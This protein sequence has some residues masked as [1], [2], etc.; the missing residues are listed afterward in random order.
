MVQYTGVPAEGAHSPQL[1]VVKGE[2]TRVFLI[3]NQM[4]KQPDSITRENPR[5]HWDKRELNSTKLVLFQSFLIKI[6]GWKTGSA[7]LKD[8]LN[9]KN[10]E[11]NF[12]NR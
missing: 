6:Y 4:R 9:F 10:K 11:N 3:K 1:I 8:V 5:S 12:Y 2:K 7:Q